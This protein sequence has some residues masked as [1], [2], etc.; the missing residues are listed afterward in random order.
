MSYQSI[1]ALWWQIAFI[2]IAGWIATDLWRVVGVLLG[3]RIDEKSE[4]L[5][6]VRAIAT[7]LVAAVIAQ[8]IVFPTGA[9]ADN[10]SFA[11]RIIAASAGFAAY[12]GSGQR[13][14]VGVL[15][16]LAVLGLAMVI[17]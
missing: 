6:L 9:L 3:N 5:V 8:L 7:A 11:G 10:T 2:L 4:A 16:A 17:A 1:D 15:T 12:L 13:I 14:A